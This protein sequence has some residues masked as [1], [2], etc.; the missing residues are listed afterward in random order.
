M[1]LIHKENTLCVP[2]STHKGS[3]SE[4]AALPASFFLKT[5]KLGYYWGFKN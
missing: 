3:P 2:Y 1:N 4:I 5:S